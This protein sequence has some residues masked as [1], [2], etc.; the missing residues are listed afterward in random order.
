MRERSQLEP[1][2]LLAQRDK[3]VQRLRDVAALQ[4]VLAQ[5]KKHVG[6]SSCAKCTTGYS[7][8]IMSHLSHGVLHDMRVIF[9]PMPCRLYTSIARDIMLQNE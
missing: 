8:V 6:V 5:T 3:V 1:E 9:P 7:G 4:D 2:G